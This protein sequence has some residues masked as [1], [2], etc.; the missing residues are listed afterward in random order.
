M[1]SY[2]NAVEA[3]ANRLKEIN[4]TV[5]DEDMMIVL[6]EQPES[7][8]QL[9]VALESTDSKVLTYDLVVERLL[10]EEARQSDKEGESSLGSMAL[11]ARS[12]KS[13]TDLRRITC[14]SCHRKGHYQSDCPNK[15][16]DDSCSDSSRSSSPPRSHAGS[17]RTSRRRSRSHR[18]R[19]SKG[20]YNIRSKGGSAHIAQHA[21]VGIARLGSGGVY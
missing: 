4:V 11:A 18:N 7:Y 17:T 2:I 12:Q 8:D 13:K 3:M 1:Q 15:C 21:T 16:D 5:T 9:I 10:N 14:F 20:T 19:R 6:L